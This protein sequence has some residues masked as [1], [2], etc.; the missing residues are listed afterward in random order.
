M[1]YG[2][3]EKGRSSGPMSCLHVGLFSLRSHVIYS[4]L[5]KFEY[6]SIV[7]S[8]RC[9][10]QFHMMRE[11]RKVGDILF[12]FTCT[13]DLYPSHFSALS[14]ISVVRYT[15]Y[16]SQLTVGNNVTCCCGSTFSCVWC[17]EENTSEP[18][19]GKFKFPPWGV[20]ECSFV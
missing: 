9:I 4:P 16:E 17:L 12:M 7:G 8:N 3:R 10:C 5:S 11:N 14:Q 6:I 19:S 2:A 1:S 15:S 18:S 20:G 13:H